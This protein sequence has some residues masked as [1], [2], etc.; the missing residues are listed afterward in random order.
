MRG[1]DQIEAILKAEQKRRVESNHITQEY[2][3]SFLDKL[4]T[5]LNAKV[6]TQFNQ[7]DSRISQVSEALTRVEGRFEE[8][9]SSVSALLESKMRDSDK[10]IAEAD[11]L[12]RNVK[13]SFT[14]QNEKM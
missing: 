12:L 5:S 7:V 10:K 4:E 2:I 9:Q 3:H 14:L 6:S 11:L 8:Q 13:G 1:I